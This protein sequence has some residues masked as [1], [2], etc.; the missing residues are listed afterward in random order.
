MSSYLV[1]VITYFHIFKGLSIVKLI[2]YQCG[3][4][5][6]RE[7]GLFIIFTKSIMGLF[8]SS[9][10]L[11]F[12]QK[13]IKRVTYH[14]YEVYNGFVYVFKKLIFGQKHINYIWK[15]RPF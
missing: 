11:L 12:V 5:P 9:R 15:H 6:F 8:M 1:F 13:H 14:F 10:N 7:R 4:K 3:T 2:L